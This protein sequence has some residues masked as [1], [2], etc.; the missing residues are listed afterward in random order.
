MGLLIHFTSKNKNRD[1]LVYIFSFIWSIK[2][3]IYKCNKLINVQDRSTIKQ[4]VGPL[5]EPTRK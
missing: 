3:K 4:I 5:S 1:V 2:L